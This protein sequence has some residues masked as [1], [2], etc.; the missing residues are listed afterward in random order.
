MRGTVCQHQP[1]FDTV[2]SYTLIFPSQL[3]KASKKGR[4]KIP[5]KTSYV[6]FIALAV[7]FAREK[8]YKIFDHA[9]F[10]ILLN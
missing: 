2:F 6:D 3:I 10:F 5:G 9:R 1:A 8:F 7:Q 4:Y